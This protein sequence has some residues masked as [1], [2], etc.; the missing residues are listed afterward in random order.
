MMTNFK[1]SMGLLLLSLFLFKGLQGQDTYMYEPSEENP[2]GTFHPKMPD[3][4]RDWAPMIG[5][6]NCKSISR[7]NQ[8]AWGDTV[9]MIWRFKYIMNGMAV[10][11]ETL[12][13]DGLHSGSIRQYIPDSAQWYVHYYS[14][15]TPSTV[16]S[17]WEG[18]KQENGDIVLYREQKATN[19][20]DGYYKINFYNISEDGFDW[21]GEW[22][23]K[24]ES[25]SYTTWKIFCM[26]RKT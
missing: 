20:M 23:S 14:S 12:K 9:N 1:L 19:G 10:Q 5:E 25:F 2:F 24:D 7:I 15:G 8:T 18:N 3:E 6:C 4:I 21:R 22:V 11:D 26:K 17:T 16:L 13:E